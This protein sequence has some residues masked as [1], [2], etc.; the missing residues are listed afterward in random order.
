MYNSASP[1]GFNFDPYPF[2]LMNLILSTVVA[3]QA[4]VV[5]MN[6]NRQKE[7]DRMRSENNCLI[8]L[9][10]EIEIRNLHQ[11]IDLLLK[12]QIKDPF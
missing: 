3:L 7:K 4:P 12:G 9:K 10:A 5:T 8:N 1:N 11:K 2:I 6:Q